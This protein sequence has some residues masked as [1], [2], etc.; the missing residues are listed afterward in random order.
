[1]EEVAP[2]ENRTRNRPR[3][4]HRV[5]ELQYQVDEVICFIA[6]TS[7]HS[8]SAGN[9]EG[10]EQCGPPLPEIPA[11]PPS[12]PLILDRDPVP[13]ELVRWNVHLP[14]HILNCVPLFTPLKLAF[15]LLN[16]SFCFIWTRSGRPTCPTPTLTAKAEGLGPTCCHR[17]N[18]SG[19]G[20]RGRSPVASCP[21]SKLC[22]ASVRQRGRG[23]RGS[24]CSSTTKVCTDACHLS[25]LLIYS[26]KLGC[27]FLIKKLCS[28]TVHTQKIINAKGI[29]NQQRSLTSRKYELNKRVI[30][31]M[32]FSS[33]VTGI[34]L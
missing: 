17:R 31:A 15:P 33:C 9:A 16:L 29:S 26:F 20:G 4:S 25:V 3:V 30:S 14:P 27:L 11:P 1:M 21:S 13:E 24:S 23:W 12:Y 19:S 28:Q 6:I 10:L 18:G 22:W 34:S 2:S 32:S 5:T 8:I 7:V